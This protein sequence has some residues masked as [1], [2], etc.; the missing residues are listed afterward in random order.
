MPGNPSHREEDRPN[1]N[2]GV[3]QHR[4]DPGFFEPR[5]QQR[6]QGGANRNNIPRRNM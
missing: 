6:P 4:R 2:R 1:P 3:P 5:P